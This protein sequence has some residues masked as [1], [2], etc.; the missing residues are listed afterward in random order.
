M[1]TTRHCAWIALHIIL[2]VR[3]T[4]APQRVLITTNDNNTLVYV[5]DDGM[6]CNSADDCGKYCWNRSSSTSRVSHWDNSVDL[7]FMPEMNAD[8]RQL[9]GDWFVANYVYPRTLCW[10]EAGQTNRVAY[11]P[12]LENLDRI[13]KWRQ[14]A[15]EPRLDQKANDQK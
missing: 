11:R 3:V 12:S 10:T 8:K 5:V 7:F 13:R 2:T 14:L 9:V 6:K 1:I 15:P 4:A